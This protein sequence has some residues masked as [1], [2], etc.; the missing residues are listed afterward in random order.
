MKMIRLSGH[1][2]ENMRYRGV[3]G[4]EIFEAIQTAPWSPAEFRR[5][6]CRKDF[7]YER[8]WNNKFCRTKQVR[9]IFVEEAEEI[10]VITVYAYYF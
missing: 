4:W 5:L 9:P 1:A 3:E 6:E 10:V 8:D 2:Q 7:V